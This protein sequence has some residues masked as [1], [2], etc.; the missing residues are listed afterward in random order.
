[1]DYTMHPTQPSDLGLHARQKLIVA[2]WKMHG[3]LSA[4]AALLAAIRNGLTAEL[5]QQPAEHVKSKRPAQIAVC[6]PFP[7][8]AQ[9]QAALQGSV[10]AWGAQDVSNHARGA[11]TGEV[12]ASMLSEFGAQYVLVGHSERRTYHHETD[13]TIAQKTLRALEAGITPIVCVGESRQARDA[14]DTEQVVGEQ[15]QAVLNVL[16]AAQIQKIIVAYEPVWAIGAARSASPDEAQAVHAYLRA[17][18]AKKLE[19]PAENS[20]HASGTKIPAQAGH[21]NTASAWSIPLLYGGS[22]KAANAAALLAQPDIDGGLIGGASLDASEFL[23]IYTA[24]Q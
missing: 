7:Y 4:N 14:G 3:T 19:L 12:A 16:S 17:Q 11:Y 23:A 9:V 13:E 2:N 22:M 15:L 24:A 1:M 21:S 10:L 5:A 20:T 18:L 8:L 6:V